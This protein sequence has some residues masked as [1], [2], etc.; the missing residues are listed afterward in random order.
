MGPFSS[1][2]LASH[3]PCD[4]VVLVVE[5]AVDLLL[6]LSLNL[7][8]SFQIHQLLTSNSLK[9]SAKDSPFVLLFIGVIAIGAFVCTYLLASLFLSCRLLNRTAVDSALSLPSVLL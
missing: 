3:G 5:L 4:S 1:L 9:E 2:S 6:Y 7:H 8:H